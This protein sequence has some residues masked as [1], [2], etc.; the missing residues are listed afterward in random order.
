MNLEAAIRALE[1]AFGEAL[2]VHANGHISRRSFNVNDRQGN[3][4]MIG[5]MG[6]A[7]SIGLGVALSRPDRQ[8]IVLDGDGNV[9]MNLAGL[10]SIAARRPGNLLHIC[11]DNGAY[12]STGNQPTLARD[13]RLE[14]LA[15][16][17]G[18]ERV[19]R[20]R[21]PEALT[22]TATAM[23]AAGGPAFLLAEIET[24]AGPFTAARVSHSPEEIRDRFARAIAEPARAGNA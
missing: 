4:Y 23:L 19:A 16:A 6:L 12:G 14:E 3:F 10:V 24:D 5:S 13:C 21:T 1:P 15:A 11:L 20:V 2:V 18:Y 8:V 9:L 7:S 22:E 17:A